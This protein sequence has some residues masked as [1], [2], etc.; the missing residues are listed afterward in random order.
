MN[1]AKACIISCIDYRFH[2]GINKFLDDQGYKSEVDLISIAGAS[3]DL[4]RPEDPSD[5]KYLWKQIG[6]S[7]KLHDPQDFVI[8]DHQD[9]GMYKATGE[10]RKGMSFEEDFNVHKSVL[11]NLKSEF[12]KRFPKFQGTL[13]IWFAKLDGTVIPIIV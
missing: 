1:R 13:H 8:I 9:C 6:I 4:V 11:V 5:S 10:V 12:L 3:H 2:D 7:L